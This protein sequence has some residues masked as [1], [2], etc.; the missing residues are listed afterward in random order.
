VERTNAW[1]NGFNRL[2]R[3]EER[4]EDVID[5]SSPMNR[6]WMRWLPGQRNPMTLHYRPFR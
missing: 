2:Q 3:C 4:D 1:H 5:G 6:M